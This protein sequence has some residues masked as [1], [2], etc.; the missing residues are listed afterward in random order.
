M[1]WLQSSL[2][3]LLLCS[4]VTSSHAANTVQSFVADFPPDPFFPY[5]YASNLVPATTDADGFLRMTWEGVGSTTSRIAFDQAYTDDWESMAINFDMRIGQATT[6]GSQDPCGFGADGIGVVL[7]NIDNYG[8]R[9]HVNW[10]GGESPDLAGSFGVGFDTWDNGDEGCNSVSL[11]WDGAVYDSFPI[12]GSDID[13]FETGEVLNTTILLENAGGDMEVSVILTDGTDTIIPW[14]Q[15]PIPFDP[16]VGRL[17]FGARTGGAWSDQDIANITLTVDGELKQEVLFPSNYDAG[18]PVAPPSLMGGTPYAARQFGSAPGPVLIPL[19][20]AGG[21]QDGFLRLASEVGSNDNGIVFDQTSTGT[22]LIEANFDFRIQDDGLLGAADGLSFLLVPADTYGTTGPLFGG[23]NPF[24][25]KEEPNLAGAL[26]LAFDIYQSGNDSEPCDG[27]S[28]TKANEVSLHWN[29]GV[30]SQFQVPLAE[31]DW[32]GDKFHSVTMIVEQVDGD[33]N[34]TAYI[35]DGTDDNTTLLFT[36]EFI[37]DLSFPGGARAAFYAHTGGAADH[38]ELDNINIDFGD[39]SIP[40]D[41]NGNGVLDAADLDEMAAAMS[42]PP[43]DPKYDL[44]GD[45]EVDIADREYWV[46]E[47]KNTWIGDA[48]LDLEFNSGD[49]VQVFVGGKYET[50]GDATWAKAT[51]TATRCLA[52]VTWWPRLL[53]GVTN[54]VLRMAAAAV[55]EPTSLLLLMAGLMGVAICRRHLRS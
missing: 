5:R 44:T 1:K 50:G 15:E 33:A 9:G 37:S 7:A 30:I 27:C 18:A 46:N 2:N 38:F 20:E 47:L 6:G 29:G 41:F 10:A 21:T 24:P 22:N 45:G 16:Y 25:T 39:V 8:R 13:T 36:D 28:G 49:M 42:D 51:G 4:L 3:M 34:V 19:D 55:P 43:V 23:A 12:E 31:I 40:G 11:H 53:P 17:A 35:V 14:E 26:G 32:A 48:N 54:R 52:A